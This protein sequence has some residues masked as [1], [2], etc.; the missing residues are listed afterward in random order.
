M[1]ESSLSKRALESRSLYLQ[2]RLAFL[3]AVAMMLI[4]IA[5]LLVLTSQQP[6]VHT[7]GGPK[8][9]YNIT[10][11]PLYERPTPPVVEPVENETEP[12]EEEE[13]LLGPL[14]YLGCLQ[15]NEEENIFS[16]TGLN[17]D[18][19]SVKNIIK[20]V[21]STCDT[22]GADGFVDRD[23]IVDT[24]VYRSQNTWV[25]EWDCLADLASCEI[26]KIHLAVAVL[27]KY[28]PATDAF[29]AR[30]E[31]FKFFV[32]YKDNQ[33]E[34]VRKFVTTLSKPTVEALYNDVYHAG[35]M[36]EAIFPEILHVEKGDKFCFDVIADRSCV[37]SVEVS[38]FI[39]GECPQLPADLKGICSA[40]VGEVYLNKGRNEI[41][42]TVADNATATFYTYDFSLTSG[43]DYI[44]AGNAFIR[45]SD[46][47]C[48]VNDS[49][50]GF[51]S[52]E[53]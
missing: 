27:R 30:T 39:V 17:F 51:L 36:T 19:R 31:N 5:L 25:C 41:C 15:P 42:F 3:G 12:V 10:T 6:N 34:W 33:G 14:D 9:P 16:A 24:T 53:D 43:E 22:D 47:D 26:Y 7:P 8:S 11:A 49:F 18:D 45:K 48:C 29:V 23:C 37:C 52:I 35:P 28:V 32:I 46:W 21:E 40:P 20:T 50:K 2:R 38:P 13:C 4:V 44:P 1:T